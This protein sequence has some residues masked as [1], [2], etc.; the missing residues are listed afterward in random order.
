[1]AKF[2]FEKIVRDK[3]PQ[4]LSDQDITYVCKK[5]SHDET[6]SALKDKLI[7]EAQEVKDAHSQDELREE[8]A[9]T[10]EVIESLLQHSGLSWDEID[11]ARN[12]KNEKRGAFKDAVYI[13][14]VESYDGHALEKY[15]HEDP[16]KYPHLYSFHKNGAEIT[17]HEHAFAP[18]DAKILRRL[19]SF[20]APYLGSNPAQYFTVEARERTAHW[21]RQWIYQARCV[22]YQCYL[23]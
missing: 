18:V 17:L 15:H 2:R 21:R 1:M 13:S 10:L 5:L 4:I 14:T 8:I 22:L 9:D 20:N 12:I 23:L 16:L 11:Y 7:E 3:V 19:R 6:L